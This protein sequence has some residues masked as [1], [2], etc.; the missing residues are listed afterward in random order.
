MTEK[1]HLELR[2]K[3]NEIRKGILLEVY[4]AQSGHPGGALSIADMMTYLYEKELN[5]NPQNPDWADRDRL[6]LSKGHVCPALYAALAQQGYFSP[7]ELK[8]F[9]QS[10]SRLQGHPD[11]NKV[12]GVDFSAGSLGQGMSAAVGMALMGKLG[13]KSYRVYAILGDGELQEGQVWESAMFAASRELD[14]L[15]Y[16]VDNNGLQID[17]KIE[18][19]CSPY[20]IN[21]KFTAFGFEV[22]S[23]DGH[24]FEEIE[25]A[26]QM[27][28]ATKGKPVALIAK[29]IK[30]KGV[31]YMENQAAWHGSAPNEEQYTIAM[32]EL[33]QIDEELKDKGG[34]R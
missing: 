10:G 27:A 16:I 15:C 5:I 1:E 31:S 7:E 12:P 18:E 3:A 30:G 21:E 34:E 13:N 32:A 22:I 8:T 4:S 17:G 28:K 11:M 19:V 20:P 23:L 2:R 26:F 14:N 24:D 29:T 25:A 6:V 9:R 33:A